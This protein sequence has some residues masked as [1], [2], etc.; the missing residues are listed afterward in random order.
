VPTRHR[1]VPLTR[2][3]VMEEGRAGKVK[4]LGRVL[5]PA[6]YDH[7]QRTAS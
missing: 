7:F 4:Y 3:G 5:P 6:G 1:K 2:I